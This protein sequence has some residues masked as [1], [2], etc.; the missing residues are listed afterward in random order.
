MAVPLK[1]FWYSFNL[2]FPCIVGNWL[3]ILNQFF[4]AEELIWVS[5]HVF[6]INQLTSFSQW[7]GIWTLAVSRQ[8]FWSIFSRIIIRFHN[9]RSFLSFIAHMIQ[10]AASQYLR[11]G[12]VELSSYWYS[13]QNPPAIHSASL[14]KKGS[15]LFPSGVSQK[16]SSHYKKD[17]KELECC[18]YFY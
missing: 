9:H 13:C 5:L 8:W 3:K 16:D 12:F 6:C 11:M 14:K 7:D 4:Q 1:S 15:I 2:H 10:S 18:F 17:F